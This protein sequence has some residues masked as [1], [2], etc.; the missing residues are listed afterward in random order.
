MEPGTYDAAIIGLV[1]KPGGDYPV[2]CYDI[3]KIIE[4]LKSDDGMSEE[5]AWEFYYFNIEGAYMGNGTPMF[6][7]TTESLLSQ[8]DLSQN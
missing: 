6:I 8:C 4:I 3:N 7:T 2:V 1:A 5:D